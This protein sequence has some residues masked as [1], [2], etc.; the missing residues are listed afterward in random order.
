VLVAYAGVGSGCKVV[1]RDGPHLLDKFNRVIQIDLVGTFNALRL[2]A[3]QMMKNEPTEGGER[4][5][6]I[7]VSSIAAW[8]GQIGQS[9]YS[10]AKGGVNGLVLTAVRDLASSGI[11][12]MGIAPGF[13]ATPQVMRMPDKYIQGICSTIPFPSRPG[14]PEEF[15]HLVNAIIENEF[16][17][18][19]V[20]RLDGAIRMQPR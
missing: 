3:E 15:A 2:C 12:V 6:I 8:E 10:A 13:M 16:L 11:R 5:V 17:N 7:C 9:A 14:K 19:S 4:G 20:I 18:G 1:G